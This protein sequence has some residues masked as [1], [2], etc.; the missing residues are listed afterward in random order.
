M[1]DLFADR[2]MGDVQI[3]RGLDKLPRRA[4]ASKA[5]IALRGR[6]SAMGEFFSPLRGK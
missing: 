3:L 5:L 2:P 6:S 1:S 4:A